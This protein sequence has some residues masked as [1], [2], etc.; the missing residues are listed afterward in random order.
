MLRATGHRS[1]EM[2]NE[3]AQSPRWITILSDRG[4]YKDT[5]RKSENQVKAHLLV[6][7]K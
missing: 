6:E 2:I 1:L 7:M 5:L 4:D 3:R